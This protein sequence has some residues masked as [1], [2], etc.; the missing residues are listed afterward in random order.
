M[1]KDLSNRAYIVTGGA[2]GIGLA[3]VRAIIDLGGFALAV[4]LQEESLK[5]VAAMFSDQAAQF[6]SLA[7]DV[8]KPDSDQQ[9]VDAAINRFGRIDGLVACA[10]RIKV[11]P[12]QE[13]TRA[14]WEAILSLNLTSVFFYARATA[15]AIK[16]AGHAGSIVTISSTSAH[17]ARPNNPDYGVSKIGIDHITRTLALEYASSQIRV[18]AVSPGVVETSMWHTV[19]KERGSV[20]G[21]APGELTAR[22]C[23]A[24]PLG[25]T[26]SAEEIASVITFL[27]SDDASFVTGQIVEADGG[28]KLANP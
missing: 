21:L 22:M 24:T 18:N 8:T 26:G 14:D 4:D 12:L 11:R 19:E 15:E 5:K 7:L 9:M 6:G 25:R 17:G 27:L 13:V 23:Q 10:G 20:L 1:K 28:F 3:T 16:K 2:S